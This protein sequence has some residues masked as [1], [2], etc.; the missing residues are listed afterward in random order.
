VSDLTATTGQPTVLLA[1]S[2]LLQTQTDVEVLLGHMVERISQA[3]GA[4]RATL[5]LVDRERQE[6]YSKAAQLP[7]LD[8]IRLPIGQGVAGHVALSGQPVTIRSA[9]QDRRFM[10]TVDQSTGYTT[11]SLLA[12]PVL[13]HEREAGTAPRVV[14]VLEALNKQGG[15]SFDDDDLALLEAL[16]DQVAEALALTHLDDSYDR[17][18]RYNGIVGASAPMREVYEVIASAAATD[19]TVLV[20]GESG[21]GKELIARAIHANSRRSTGPFVKVDCT[22]IPEGLIEAE[23]FG[24]EKGSFTGADRTVKG[25]CEI[26]SGGTLFLDEIG[27]MPLPLQAKLLRFVQDRELERVGGRQVIK[28]DV[29]VV[30][31]TNRD[32]EDAVRRGAFRKD[33]FYR[34]KVVNVPLPPLRERG[35]DDVIQLARHFLRLYARRH[36]K[37]A[38]SF[39]PAT[40][41]ALRGHPWP[42]NIRELEHCVESAVVFC[43]GPV[44]MP[45]HLSL[46]HDPAGAIEWDEPTGQRSVPGG[47]TLAELEK[48]YIIRTLAQCDGNR[49]RAATAL[50]I[51]RNT[52]GRKL[53][54]YGLE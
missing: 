32:L 52:L 15:G 22:A 37:P 28:A 25:K 51:G 41:A 35:G 44:V 49:T 30:A 42:G 8:E 9:R 14:G 17:P 5:F 45:A 48:R 2:S 46:P 13:S 7:E 31:A 16:A 19:A 33:L 39:D 21:T 24:H 3:M 36:A 10:Q 20:L 34:I 50:G 4:D 43:R 40:V 1:L 53:K 23:L 47:L 27:D 12:V 29:R 26:A 6:L 54:Q 38:R 18:V 11:E